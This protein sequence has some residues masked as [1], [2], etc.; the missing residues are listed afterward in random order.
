MS[1]RGRARRWELAGAALLA[2]GAVAAFAF[3]P[4]YPTYDSYYHLVWGRELLHGTSP[5]FTAYAA[6]TEHPLYVAVAALVALAGEG[7]DRLLVLLTLLAFAGLVWGLI[8]LGAATLGGWSGV[9]AAVFAATSFALF[10]YAAQAYVDVWFLALVIWAAV[11]AA[12]RPARPRAAVVL[13]LVG[14]GLLRPEAWGLAILYAVWHRRGAAL[15]ARIG[16]LAG[17]IV[18][19]LAWAL[20]D[21]AVTGDALYS[22]HTTRVLSIEPHPQPGLGAFTDAL[23]ASFGGAVRLPIVV[24][25]LAGLALALARRGRERVLIPLALAAV[26]TAAALVT[27]LGGLSVLPRYLTLPAVALCLFAGAALQALAELVPR[28]ARRAAW[29]MAAIAAIVV[30]GLVAAGG[31]SPAGRLDSELRFDRHIHASLVHLIRAPAV[32]AAMR[33]G[34]LAFPTYRLVPDARWVLDEP[35]VRVRARAQAPDAGGAIVVVVGPGRALQRYGQAA[36]TVPA[37]DRPPARAV[38]VSRQGPFDAYARCG[39]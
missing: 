36:G 39:G 8:R 15:R 38:L 34:P 13:L 17:V 11:I 35:G 31:G 3:A 16:L 30:I 37:L 20:V 26:G 10:L 19:P 27:S 24:L 33:C 12:E 28:R 29:A 21:L 4:S 9:A 14:A 2:L 1:A 18:A 32:Q 22:L 6:P 23:G 5:S 25:G 7:G